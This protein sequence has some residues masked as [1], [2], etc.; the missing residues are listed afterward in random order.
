MKIYAH[1]LG[2]GWRSEDLF[3]CCLDWFFTLDQDSI[4]L[5]N[6]CL[7]LTSQLLQLKVY[8]NMPS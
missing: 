2:L 7:P 1:I 5:T 6:I 4:K 3:F 8:T